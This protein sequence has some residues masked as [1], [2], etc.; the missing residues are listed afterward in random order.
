MK[1]EINEKG[2]EAFYKEVVNISGQYRYLLQNRNYKLKD[3]FKQFTRLLIAGS[4]VLVLLIIMCL[5]WGFRTLDYVVIAF[6]ALTMLMC[7]F[8]VLSLNR[9]LKT[10]MTEAGEA[11]VTLDED[12]I[13]LNKKGAQ[14]FRNSWS[15]TE[16]VVAGKEA[17]AFLPKM[18][19]GM[20]I[21]IEKK[22][23]EAILGWLKENRAEIE[24]RNV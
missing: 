8:Y 19:T 14:V 7:A 23:E 16:C 17:V 5:A 3:Y 13:E 15:N 21:C 18:K 1:I 11:S 12:G 20:I 22:F 10:L 4:I 6:L 9:Y 24:V 2:S